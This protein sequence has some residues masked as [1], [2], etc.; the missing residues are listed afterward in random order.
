MERITIYVGNVSARLLSY[1]DGEFELV[2]W[3]K[4][5]EKWDRPLAYHEIRAIMQ[6]IGKMIQAAH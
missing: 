1:E 3:D 6:A 5:N 2:G 4:E